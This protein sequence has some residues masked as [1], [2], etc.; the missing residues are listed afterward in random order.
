MNTPSPTTVF[1]IICLL[2][3]P[4]CSPL[5]PN[6]CGRRA[7]LDL[8]RVAAASTVFLTPA[9][10]A[11]TTATTTVAPSP[12]SFAAAPKVTHKIFFDVRIARADGTFAT[13]D[14]DPDPVYRSSLVFGLYGD[15]APRHVSEFM[16]YIDVPTPASADDPSNP[17]YA[18]SLFPAVIPDTGLIVGGKIK[19]L[20][21]ANFNGASALNYGGR[22]LPSPLWLESGGEKLKHDRS[23]LLTH[24]DLDPLPLFGVTTKGMP[25]LDETHTVFGQVLEGGE[26]MRRVEFL[27]T[28]SIS[29][30]SIEEPGS[31]SESVFT[32]QKQLFRGAAK[33]AG[34]KRLEDLYEG[35]LLRKVDVTRVG[36]LQ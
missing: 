36:V 35:K 34:D 9:A 24:R 15:L 13:R 31:V 11:D 20:E 29:T 1:F 28:Y 14:N 6:I 7:V 26:F 16:K 5:T 2:V 32:F 22:L 12:T 8:G 3:L 30:S 10:R 4:R 19:G 23:G 25:S 17:S 21:P 18:S 33:A 27:P